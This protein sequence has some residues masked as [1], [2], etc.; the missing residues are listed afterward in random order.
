MSLPSTQVH[1]ASLDDLRAEALAWGRK[2][3]G[4]GAWYVTE[5]MVRA[6]RAYGWT[7]IV[8]ALGQPIIYLLGLGIGLAALIQNP[9]V[10]GGVEVD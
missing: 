10:D 7:I 2:A 5:H 8:G 9:I 1:D 6:M 4:R 3:R